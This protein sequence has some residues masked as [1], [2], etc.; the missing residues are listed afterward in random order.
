MLLQILRDDGAHVRSVILDSPQF[1]QTDDLTEAIE[2]TRYVLGRLEA[3]CRD[4][5]ACAHAFP[6]LAATIRQAET[7][8]HA[9][10]VASRVRVP[11][12]G[13]VRVLVDAGAFVRALRAMLTDN[14]SDLAP[15]VPLAAARAAHGDVSIVAAVLA[16]T[17]RPDRELCIG[18][19]PKC[20][21]YDFSLGVYLSSMCRDEVPFVDPSQLAASTGGEVGLKEAFADPPILDECR[22]WNVPPAPEQIRTA[23]S[24]GIPMLIASGEYDAYSP[25]PL[26]KSATQDLPR[27]FLYVVPYFGHNVHSTAAALRIRNG[28]IDRPTSPPDLAPLDKAQPAAFALPG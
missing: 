9:H 23:V 11:G 6:H 27:A 16:G 14:H 10:P 15:Q 18:Y 7:R 2:G 3:T 8:L 25:Y 21:V 20:G 13:P 24:S 19:R 5:P 4:D 22:A 28:W 1:F 12:A 17:T 26:D